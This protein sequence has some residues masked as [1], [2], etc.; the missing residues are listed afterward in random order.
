VAARPVRLLFCTRS[1]A[2]GGAERQLAVLAA[3]LKRRGHDVRVLTLYA[4]GPIADEL[5]RA[6]VPVDSVGKQGRWNLIG[7]LVRLWRVARRRRPEIIH[8]YLT[9]A[10]LL[11]LGLRA[12]SP[13]CRV[14]W[15]IRASALDP[16][17]YDWLTHGL[18]RVACRL[19]RRADL[20]IANSEAGRADHVRCGYPPD[21]TVVI[22]N[23]I[24][25]ERF[26][27]DPIA[28]QAV[29]AEWGVAEGDPLVGLVGRLDPMKQHST[30]LEAAALVASDRASPRFVCLGDGPP[31]YGQAVL[32]QARGLGLAERLRL[33]P[34][35]P[36][37]ARC[38][39]ALDLLVSASAFGEGFS[40]VLGEAMACGV[41]CVATD[42]GDA[43]TVIGDTGLVVPPRDPAMLARGIMTML[44]RLN[45][46]GRPDPRARILAEYS[47]GQLVDRTEEALLE[48]TLRQRDGR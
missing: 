28:R 30:F 26:R 17:V 42:V 10:N 5:A 16:D 12:A 7:P 34:A 18:W 8:G 9:D 4:G 24:D 22:P 39:P 1:L 36:D 40:N 48:L 38:Y 21:R 35:R 46:P 3:G 20:I 27:P 32:D 2:Y 33:E 43:E 13:G 11:A 31:E 45:Q 19:A 44:D 15:G 41:P 47:V 14:V 25:A 6:G 37:I 23:G 29:R